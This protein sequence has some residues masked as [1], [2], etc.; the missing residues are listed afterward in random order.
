MLGRSSLKIKCGDSERINC[1]QG[2]LAPHC[3]GQ[4][5]TV[6]AASIS[7][8]AESCSLGLTT[9]AIDIVL[10]SADNVT[11]FLL[12]ESNGSDN[13]STVALGTFLLL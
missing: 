11:R 7:T 8:E 12:K 4:K 2:W 9:L 1:L 10:R 5:E 13:A 6:G 3:S